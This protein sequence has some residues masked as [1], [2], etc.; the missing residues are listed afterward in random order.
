[1]AT[2]RVQLYSDTVSSNI[3]YSAPDDISEDDVALYAR[4]RGR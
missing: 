2:Q 1:M 3:A 4:P